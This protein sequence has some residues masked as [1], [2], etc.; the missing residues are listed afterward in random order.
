M[1]ES[2]EHDPVQ[3]EIVHEYDGIKEADN[4]LPRW[5]LGI[6]F[7]TIA[8]AFGYWWVYESWGFL[9]TPREDYEVELA[10]AAERGGVEVDDTLLETLAA[11]DTIVARGRTVFTQNCVVCHGERGEGRIGPNLTDSAWLHGDR[12]TEIYTTI[13][14]GYAPRG[15][16]AWGASLGEGQ[17]Q[18]LAAFVLSVRGANLPG[19][20]PEGAPR[21]A[22]APSADSPPGT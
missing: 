12:P 3:G 20:P 7:A 4:Q 22:A 1:S 14:D 8:F 6:F 10:R 15:M 13:R 16:P 11:N 17:V 21:E 18:A 5:W 2:N 9:S 19:R